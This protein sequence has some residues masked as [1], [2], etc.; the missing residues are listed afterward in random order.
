MTAR[1]RTVAIAKAHYTKL[2]RI[3]PTLTTQVAVIVTAVAIAITVIGTII[4]ITITEA[5]TKTV[6]ASRCATAIGVMASI[7]TQATMPV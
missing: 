4:T 1:I 3:A 2:M 7:A 5:K 6:T